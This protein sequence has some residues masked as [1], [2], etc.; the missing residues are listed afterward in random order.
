MTKIKGFKTVEPTLK[1]LSEDK[2]SLDMAITN[3]LHEE[4]VGD[5]TLIDHLLLGSLLSKNKSFMLLMYSSVFTNNFMTIDISNVFKY[6]VKSID[7]HSK[8]LAI[9]LTKL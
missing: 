1:E 6:T 3:K 9:T 4:L 5:S 8:L 2:V 7:S